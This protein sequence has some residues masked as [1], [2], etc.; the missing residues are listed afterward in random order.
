M[1]VMKFG[2]TSVGTAEAMQLVADA[3]SKQLGGKIVVLSASAGITDKLV[4]I[5]NSL[6]ED[7]SK[8]RAIY[9]Q[10][11]ELTINISDGLELSTNSIIKVQKLLKELN[12]LIYRVELL[13]YIRENMSNRIVT[14]GKIIPS[15]IFSEYYKRK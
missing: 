15:T 3:V 7:V 10:V 5:T 11:E 1:I 4:N 9:T 6:P 13:E 2:G 8:A 12:E 14:Y